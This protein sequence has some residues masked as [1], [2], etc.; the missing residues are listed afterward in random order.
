MEKQ[1]VFHSQKIMK[2]KK[3][4]TTLIAYHVIIFINLVLIS[5]NLNLI[6]PAKILAWATNYWQQLPD[7]PFTQQNVCPSVILALPLY[8]R[9]ETIPIILYNNHVHKYGKFTQY[10]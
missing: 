1:F 4:L 9:A 5:Y 7:V 6:G 2:K 3:K 8:E 10:Q